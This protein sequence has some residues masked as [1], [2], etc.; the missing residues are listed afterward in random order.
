MSD[1]TPQIVGYV[2]EDMSRFMP[3]EVFE[4]WAAQRATAAERDQW[5]P[6]T[7]ADGQGNE[8]VSLLLPRAKQPCLMV[9]TPDLWALWPDGFMCPKAEVEEVLNPPC[10]RSDDFEVVVVTQYGGDGMPADWRRV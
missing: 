8:P 7:W 5:R 4:A 9:D 6:V 10:A 2:H 1:A 3:V